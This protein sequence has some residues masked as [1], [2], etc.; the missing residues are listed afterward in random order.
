MR[1]CSKRKNCLVDVMRRHIHRPHHHFSSIQSRNQSRLHRNWFHS[2]YP[3]SYMFSWLT[4]NTPS[5]CRCSGSTVAPPVKKLAPPPTPRPRSNDYMCCVGSG[6]SSWPRC[7]QLPQCA[8]MQ[9]SLVKSEAAFDL[10]S[11]LQRHHERDF[12]IRSIQRQTAAAA[13]AVGKRR[14]GKKK[15]SLLRSTLTHHHHGIYTRLLVI[16]CDVSTVVLH[17]TASTSNYRG[18]LR[19]AVQLWHHSDPQQKQKQKTNRGALKNFF[20]Q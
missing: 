11:P 20:G 2:L 19:A 7:W 6:Q 14:E 10:R 16:S 9:I 3:L 1:V 4:K 15:K 12:T 18:L 5:V 13:A 17:L 8:S